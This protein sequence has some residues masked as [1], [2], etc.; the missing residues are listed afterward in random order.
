MSSSKQERPRG[1]DIGA[2]KSCFPNGSL[3]WK[4]HMMQHAV[5]THK[6][7]PQKTTGQAMRQISAMASIIS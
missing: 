5:L 4:Q 1:P 6:S 2:V 7:P 3:I